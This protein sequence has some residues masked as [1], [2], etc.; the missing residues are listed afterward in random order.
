L[1]DKLLCNY[2][3]KLA[4]SEMAGLF[5]A[6]YDC[7]MKKHAAPIIATILLLLPVLYVGSYFALMWRSRWSTPGLDG[8]RETSVTAEYRFGG[9]RAK[10]LF[11]PLEQIDRQ[12]RPSEWAPR[13][14]RLCQQTKNQIAA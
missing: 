2:Q 4:P 8:W 11:W 5:R 3:A 14:E 13:P 7:A 6:R 12:V 9:N 10:Q 1:N